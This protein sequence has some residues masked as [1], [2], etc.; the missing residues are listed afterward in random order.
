MIPDR[1]DDLLKDE[2]E[3]ED[4]DE[5]LLAF[6]DKQGFV[7]TTKGFYW[8]DV[9]DDNNM[10]ELEDIYDV[11]SAKRILA[12]VIYF[13]GHS[14]NVSEDVYL[15]G[16]D[17]VYE[18][19]FAFTGFIRKLAGN[20]KEDMNM[21]D[22]IAEAC[23]SAPLE[24]ATACV[25]GNPIKNNNSKLNKVKTYFG[26]P[27][28]EKIFIILDSTI[29]GKGKSGF[30]IGT[31]GIY[32][33]Q[34][35]K[36]GKITWNELK[37]KTTKKAF[38][39]I[40]IGELDF[41]CNAGIEQTSLYAILRNIKSVVNF[42][43]EKEVKS[44]DNHEKYVGDN[45]NNTESEITIKESSPNDVR[46][47]AEKYFSDDVFGE[48]IFLFDKNYDRD[49]V[50]Y[51]TRHYSL[52]TMEDPLLIFNYKGDH[53]QGFLITTHRVIWKYRGLSGEWSIKDIGAVDSA[54]FMSYILHK[55]DQEV[56]ITGIVIQMLYY[57][58]AMLESW[59]F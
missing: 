17:N 3:I 38:S 25:Y 14:N 6:Y 15:T 31:D 33:C 40:K 11:N 37:N 44:Q 57:I 42:I 45:Y 53:E 58:V 51:I 21:I 55:F 34:S 47:V 46:L 19:I 50:K 18:F 43:D 24:K 20:E 49:A 39:S 52:E 4:E 35:N 59:Q 5:L 56:C 48:K 10:W 7:L 23:L 26:I 27:E 54:K 28:D 9:Y 30:A 32:Y 8:K 36:C 13:V 22:K 1:L 2:Y 12:N 29:L 16:I 41:V